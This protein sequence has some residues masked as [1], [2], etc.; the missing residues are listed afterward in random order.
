MDN[1]LL[2]GG[3]LPAFADILPE[4]VEPA[5]RAMLEENRTRI[6]QLERLADPTFA[7][8][9]EPLEDMQHRLTR[10]WSPVSHLNAVMNSPAIR[11]AYNACLPLL[12]D[13]QTD[14]AQ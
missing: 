3:P 2:M 7:S 10:V 9:V 11:E 4:H 5:M 14:L 8:V 13:Y 12:S 1:P 6:A